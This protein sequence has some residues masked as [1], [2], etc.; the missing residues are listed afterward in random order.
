MRFDAKI[1]RCGVLEYRNADGS[2]RRELRIPDEVFSRDTLDSF[3]L[4][5]LTNSH[6]GVGLLDSKNTTAAQIGS[7]GKVRRDDDG[8]HV[9][10]AVQV[11]DQRTIK[12]I[13]QG[14]VELSCGYRCDL[15]MQAG[16]TEGIEGIPDGLQYDAIQRNIRGNHVAV[17]GRGRSGRSV[18]LRV[19]HDDRV[20]FELAE[21]EEPGAKP[22]D[23]VM[24]KIRIDGAEVEVSEDV[25][26]AFAAKSEAVKAAEV[27]RDEATA[28]ADAAEEKAIE[29]QKRADAAES[30]EA[31]KGRVDA[32]LKLERDAA[33]V[34][35]GEEKLDAMSDE[36]IRKAVIL[37]VAPGADL[38]GKS[39]E[40]VA[41][42]FD[43]AIE[44]TPVEGDTKGADKLR[45]ASKRVDGD[46]S[47]SDA[48]KRIE[49]AQAKARTA[50]KKGA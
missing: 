43:H 14:K 46:D 15:D 49:A 24:E 9:A 13:E 50:W 17:V 19:D 32:R 45:K 44:V 31:I 5:P 8:Y 37:K 18:A 40:Y 21:P 12:H 34:L 6:P 20:S 48:Q 22:K 26:R 25:A 47:V 3:E 7:V 29:A 23:E 38:E 1:A 28:R 11:M 36:E 4:S 35:G 16:V 30:P 41:A 10:A 33:K 39:P 2:I 42:R 27:A